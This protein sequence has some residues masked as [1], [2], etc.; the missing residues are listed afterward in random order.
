VDDEETLPMASSPSDEV[1]T[2]DLVDERNARAA[3]G[4]P[5]AAAASTSAIEVV[6]NKFND[7]TT[8]AKIDLSTSAE[9]YYSQPIKLARVAE[10]L[11]AEDDVSRGEET[12]VDSTNEDNLDEIGVVLA[13]DVGGGPPV[14]VEAVA[15]LLE[16]QA[17]PPR[18]RRDAP[19]I[20]TR[21]T[22]CAEDEEFCD[23]ARMISGDDGDIAPTGSSSQYESLAEA[24][25]VFASVSNL[26]WAYLD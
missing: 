24:R 17:P 18:Y 13:A 7:L 5:A 6:R 19:S 21:S 12:A 1:V 10:Q 11:S 25:W 16:H 20:N 9:D 8:C 26:M 14:D 4:G 23:I 15:P 22:L 2:N 3:T